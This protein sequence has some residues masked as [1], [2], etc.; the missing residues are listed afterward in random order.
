MRC[1][2]SSAVAAEE[3]FHRSQVGFVCNE[4]DESFSVAHA[5]RGGR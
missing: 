5:Q 4:R 1:A 3:L 2:P